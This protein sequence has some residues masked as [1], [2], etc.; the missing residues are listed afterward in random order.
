MR[1]RGKTPE[2]ES[3]TTT[4]PANVLTLHKPPTPASYTNTEYRLETS[5]HC[6]YTRW[7]RH[8]FFVDIYADSLGAMMCRM[9]WYFDVV[10]LAAQCS[11]IIRLVTAQTEIQLPSEK[12]REWNFSDFPLHTICYVAAQHVN[13]RLHWTRWFVA[14]CYVYSSPCSNTSDSGYLLILR[15]FATMSKRYCYFC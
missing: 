4:R 10:F 13:H 12:Q 9:H 11:S 6:R 8:S 15:N 3:V 2:S 1:R 5:I 14:A 7:Q